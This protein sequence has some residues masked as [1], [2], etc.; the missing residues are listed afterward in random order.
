[1]QN[2]TPHGALIM[3]LGMCFAVTV[4]LKMQQ[5]LRRSMQHIY[6]APDFLL[7]KG[8]AFLGTLSALPPSS[9]RIDTAM[10]QG[11]PHD[12]IDI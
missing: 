12:S 2:M 9:R 10:Q 4:L 7:K 3:G 11:E 5:R 8:G 1:M 6:R